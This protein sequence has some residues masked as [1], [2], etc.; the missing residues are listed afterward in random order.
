[1]AK[2]SK[3]IK[4]TN[5]SK[6]M[7]AEYEQLILDHV[8]HF[9]SGLTIADISKNLG[10]SRITVSKYISVLEAKEKVYSKSLGA[11][12]L[13]LPLERTFIHWTQINP[14]YQGLLKGLMEEFPGDKKEVFK[15]IG[16]KMN[17]FI[18]F[19]LGSDFPKEVLKPVKGSY[20]NLL[21]YYA[22]NYK[23]MDLIFGGNIEL[24]ADINEEGNKAIYAFKD[25]KMLK[26]NESFILHFYIMCG[27]IE[28]TFEGLINKKITCRIERVYDYDVELSIQIF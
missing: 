19:P 4:K 8:N 2:K 14:Y 21:E 23:T 16:L 9:P 27:W 12:T 11:Y 1:M 15:R 18:S 26:E 22:E 6:I 5:K 28:K 25:I 13:Y 17:K 20:R 7:P 24:E 3:N 10:I